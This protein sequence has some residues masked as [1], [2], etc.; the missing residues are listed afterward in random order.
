MTLW[1]VAGGKR[2][3]CLTCYEKGEVAKAERGAVEP[4]PVQEKL[5]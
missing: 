5:F 1:R 3:H 2:S 4:A